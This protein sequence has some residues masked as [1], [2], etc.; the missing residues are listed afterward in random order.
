MRAKR[1]LA[2]VSEDVD[3]RLPTLLVGCRTS[4]LA[5]WPRAIGWRGEWG[6]GRAGYSLVCAVVDWA[7]ARCGVLGV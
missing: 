5:Q 7:A 3:A 6:D 2:S 4:L 1:A